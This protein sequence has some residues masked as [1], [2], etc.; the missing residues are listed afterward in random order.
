ML[1]RFAYTLDSVGNRTNKTQTTPRASGGN[2]V[3]KEP[4]RYDAVDQIV[5][6][7]YITNNVTTRTVSYQYDPVGN[8]QQVTDNGQITGYTAN[9]LNQYTVVD[10]SLLSYD[11]NGNLASAVGPAPYG[12]YSYSYDAQNRLLSASSVSSVVQFAYDARN[13][14]VSRTVNGV[15]TYFVWDGWSLLEERDASGA[16]IARYI[17]GATIDEI[18]LRVSG[19]ATHYYHHDALGSTIALTDGTGNVVESYT[20]D[21]YGVPSIL[22]TTYQLLTT[23]SVANRFLFTGREF[24]AEAGLYDYRNRFYSPVLGRFLQTDPIGFVAGDVNLYRYVNNQIPNYNDPS[25]Q[26]FTWVPIIGTLEQGIYVALGTLRGMKVTDYAH[27]KDPFEDVCRKKVDDAVFFYSALVGIP[28]AVR[29]GIEVGVTIGV[30][31]LGTLTAGAIVGGVS[32]VDVGVGLAIFKRATEK[33]QA[34][35][36]EAKTVY[37]RCENE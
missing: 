17:H 19:E 2:W 18:L 24:L 6:V 9:H 28:N 7:Q 20:Y 35:G 21:V 5:G 15:T 36:E 33:I 31:Y 37:C 11:A 34:A 25:G 27:C 29:F 1:P 8:R 13:R 23:S 10:G 14:C 16:Q 3:R 30:T 32:L 26:I 12:N 22:S 4:Y